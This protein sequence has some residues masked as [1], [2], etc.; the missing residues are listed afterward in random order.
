MATQRIAVIAGDGIGPEVI[1][2][3]R[4]T[5]DALQALDATLD[6]E[7]VEFPWGSA[8]YLE[9]GHMMP[10]DGIQ[11]LEEFDAIYF[12]AVGWPMIPDHVSLW[13]LLIPMRRSFDQ[14][15]NLR[16]VRLLNGV[17]SPLA[18]PGAIDFVM[19]RENTEGEY[20]DIGGHIFSGTDREVVIQ[21]SVFTRMA[22]SGLYATPTILPAHAASG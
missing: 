5:L 8:Y 9:H 2:A 17:G 16:P 4:R 10:E 3:G 14:Y 20:S 13:G 21:E 12:G 19:V 1:A 15:I 22:S 11:Q 18:H 7:Y 6:L